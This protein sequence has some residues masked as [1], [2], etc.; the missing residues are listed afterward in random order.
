MERKIWWIA[1]FPKSGNTFARMF[2]NAYVTKFPLNINANFQYATTDQNYQMFQQVS[3]KPL[4]E[5]EPIELVYL[6]PAAI[7]QYV[8]SIEPRDACFKTHNANI[9]ID[10]IPLI[11]KRL[12]K[13]AVYLVR[14]PRDIAISYAKHSGKT[15]DKT[16]EIMGTNNHVGHRDYGLQDVVMS[17][18][19]HVD[20]WRRAKFPV[21]WIR[22]EDLLTDTESTFRRLLKGIGF[23]EIDEDAL[24]F[25]LKE[26]KFE[27]LKRQ[28]QSI[29]FREAKHDRFFRAG[30]SGQWRSVLTREQIQR[31]EHNHRHTMLAMGYQLSLEMTPGEREPALAFSTTDEVTYGA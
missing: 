24:Q 17:W 4:C 10:G 31:I 5:L 28:E 7:L 29:G 9:E 8:H 21:T 22:Y 19:S 26:T 14:D 15:I 30:T 12:T 18:S 27:N 25:A 23:R 1:S 11:P 16:I 6:R 20:S 2:V 13:Q 3:A